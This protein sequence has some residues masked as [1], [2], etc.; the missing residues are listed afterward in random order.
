MKTPLLELKPTQHESS[1]Q[2]R[3]EDDRD[4]LRSSQQGLRGLRYP[5]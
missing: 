3:A 4:H 5:L 2:Q 1:V